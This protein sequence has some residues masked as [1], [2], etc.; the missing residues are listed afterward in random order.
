MD[1]V[2]GNGLTL[3]ELEQIEESA[4]HFQTSEARIVLRLAAALR[5]ALQEKESAYALAAEF[6]KK[7]DAGHR[8]SGKLFKSRRAP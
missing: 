2:A 5:E 1:R 7:A 4:H 6:K 3:T 8:N